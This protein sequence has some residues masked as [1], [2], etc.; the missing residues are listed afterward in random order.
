MTTRTDDPAA[1]ARD[2]IDAA[3]EIQG[4]SRP[5]AEAYEQ[6]VAKAEAAFRQ[7]ATARRKHEDLPRA[8]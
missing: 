1:M 8:A 6:A 5:P 3:L 2:Y 4:G 7:L